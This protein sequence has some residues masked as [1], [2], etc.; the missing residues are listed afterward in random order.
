[1]KEI[2][3]QLAPPAPP[4]YVPPSNPGKPGVLQQPPPPRFTASELQ[5]MSRGEII[6]KQLC[7]A[8]HGMDGKGTPMGGTA[9]GT[10]LAPPLSGSKTATGYRDGIIRVVLKGL[11]GPVE[12][13]TYGAQMVPMESNDDDWIAFGHFLHSCNDF[14][15]SFHVHYFQ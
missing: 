1:M 6:Y 7:F 14:Q 15:Q 4:P 2:G 8:C 11:S 5:V 9:P 12:G 13:K 3:S 10:T